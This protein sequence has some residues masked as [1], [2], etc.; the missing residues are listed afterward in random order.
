MQPDFKP[1]ADFA[2]NSPKNLTLF[3]KHCFPL[4]GF[5]L[6]TS[7][8]S[9]AQPGCPDA[10]ASNY[11]PSA[12]G[13][14][15]SCTYPL[16][17]YTP[18]FKAFLPESMLEVSG[19]VKAGGNWYLHNDGSDGSRFY[20]FT[21]ETGAVTQ[22]IQ[23]KNASNKDWEDIGAS[24]THVYLG[25]FGNN[26]NDR[27]DLGVYKVPLA[28]IGSSSS[29][30]I[31]DDEWTF[32]PFSYADQTDFSTKPQDSTVFDC[33]AMLFF[34]NK[35]HLFTKNRRDYTTSHYI[36]NQVSGKAEKLE[37]F[38][39][40][41]MITGADVSPD[42]KLI[43]LLGY[44][45]AGLPKVF[46]WLLWDWQA[47]SDLFFTGNKRRIELGS[48]LVTGQA[49]GIAFAGNRTGYIT[50]EETVANNITFVEQSVR[51]FDFGQWVPESTA[52]TEPGEEAGLG[53]FPN[54]FSGAVQFRFPGNNRPDRLRVVNQTGQV[55]FSTENAPEAVDMAA[56]PAG[57]YVFE[58]VWGERIGWIRGVKVK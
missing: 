9:F 48:A 47:G 10:Q 7:S 29:E 13:N 6:L 45:L 23:L 4:F 39:T 16:T 20:R 37:T 34:N 49:E 24:S 2:G 32:I 55:V 41:G 53:I 15:G 46:A 51:W 30:T 52:T 54:P 33:E 35:I 43:V 21:P 56:F 14:D 12:T 38:D 31:D 11:N 27:Q 57:L 22:E 1:G 5:I 19:H 36:I 44:N 40:D 17:N 58:A 26:L 42:G 28:K 25:D 18:V 8:F 50:N 3:M